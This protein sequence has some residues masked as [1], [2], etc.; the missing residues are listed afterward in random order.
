MVCC[1]LV[2]AVGLSCVFFLV[3]IASGYRVILQYPNKS[4]KREA[5]LFVPH[6]INA[7]SVESETS[8]LKRNGSVFLER[9]SGH[10]ALY[11]DMNHH[12]CIDY[13]VHDLARNT[14]KR[15]YASLRE[16]RIDQLV[17]LK[18][19]NMVL[20]DDGGVEEN[21]ALVEE[22]A[23]RASA[24]SRQAKSASRRLSV[25]ADAPPVVEAIPGVGSA[26]AE[27]S[28]H[29]I[30]LE[31]RE[32]AAV[33]DRGGVTQALQELLGRA[34]SLEQGTRRPDDMFPILTKVLEIW[35]EGERPVI[36]PIACS[37]L[38]KMVQSTYV[39]VIYRENA[40]K[41]KL[42]CRTFVLSCL[43][44]FAGPEGEGR[45]PAP[46]ILTSALHI[47]YKISSLRIYRALHR[48]ALDHVAY[49]DGLAVLLP[50]P[51]AFYYE[52]GKFSLPMHVPKGR[53]K[54]KGKTPGYDTT[55]DDGTHIIGDG[56]WLE[57]RSLRNAQKKVPGLKRLRTN[58][59]D[60]WDAQDLA[61]CPHFEEYVTLGKPVL[62]HG[63]FADAG[64]VEANFRRREFV[65][66]YGSVLYQSQG[67]GK[68]GQ[69]FADIVEKMRTAS[70]NGEQGFEVST[71]HILLEDAQNMVNTSYFRKPNDDP[72]TAPHPGGSVRITLGT[73]LY[74]SPLLQ[75]NESSS[76]LKGILFG[77][78]KWV[79]Y[80]S[81]LDLDFLL[82]SKGGNESTK[83]FKEI[84][85]DGVDFHGG[86]HAIQEPFSFFYIPK[87]WYATY[88][89]IGEVVA[90]DYSAEVMFAESKILK[91]SWEHPMGTANKTNLYKHWMP[92]A[93]LPCQSTLSKQLQEMA[94]RDLIIL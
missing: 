68:R 89:N 32:N 54:K 28:L 1:R 61:F 87:G 57:M 22:R 18:R 24:R 93:P 38:P 58:H 12:F 82:T 92:C 11:G 47:L 50:F 65:R 56:G 16:R 8:V 35:G 77:K 13:V 66:R 23:R 86:F 41:T 37:F 31:F 79:L 14:T 53:K 74:Q 75:F 3:G 67:K 80:P 40:T 45:V 59:V 51:S 21:K 73:P 48:F 43:A 83:T 26:V 78:R 17:S 39:S 5:I 64:I 81:I 19:C 20:A 25:R 30:L 60:K 44:S 62:V 7:S 34:D 88:L 42:V 9:L 36:S 84:V 69:Y 70:T 2:E 94:E 33:D 55:G 90:I 85:M 52:S 63:L 76:T 10:P 27:R 72:T 29:D 15:Q 6:L 49:S 46:R 71:T 91:Q 4:R